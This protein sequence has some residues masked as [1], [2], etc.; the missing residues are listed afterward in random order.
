LLKGLICIVFLVVRRFIIVALFFRF[1][2]LILVIFHILIFEILIFFT[3]WVLTLSFLLLWVILNLILK[4][5]FILFFSLFHLP[6]FFCLRIIVSPKTL[7][8]Q[9]LSL[10]V[11]FWITW[12]IHFTLR[13]FFIILV[14]DYLILSLPL[15]LVLL[16]FCW[17]DVWF[18]I[19]LVTF[20]KVLLILNVFHFF[21]LII[22]ELRI[23]FVTR[24]VFV[25]VHLRIFKIIWLLFI[26]IRLFKAI[27][28]LWIWIVDKL[29]F[30]L[31]LK[32]ATRLLR[33][34]QGR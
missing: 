28:L 16:R 24:A 32:S 19:V 8:L 12:H 15:C 31:I 7:L 5:I 6:R 33:L 14:Y 11:E 23:F 20:L 29:I 13:I 1:L 17:A 10:L 21:I 2:E 9:S 3:V 27:N 4:S 26:L 18:W 22:I 30:L 34:S 25:W